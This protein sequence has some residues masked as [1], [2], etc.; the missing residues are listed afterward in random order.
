MF[1]VWYYHYKKPIMIICLFTLT[2]KLKRQIVHVRLNNSNWR[3]KEERKFNLVMVQ[4]MHIELEIL[5]A[6][7]FDMRNIAET[8][9]NFSYI[10]YSL[11]SIIIYRSTEIIFLDMN[12]IQKELAIKRNRKSFYQRKRKQWVEIKKYVVKESFQRYGYLNLSLF[13]GLSLISY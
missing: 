8:I 4:K 7:L 6:F 5:F 12:C 3:A 1:Q 9:F 10:T 11:L 2:R 13:N